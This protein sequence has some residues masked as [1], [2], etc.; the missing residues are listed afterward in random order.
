MVVT[1]IQMLTKAPSGT[2]PAGSGAPASAH[3]VV[4]VPP[5]VVAAQEACPERIME[6]FFEREQRTKGGSI[7]KTEFWTNTCSSPKRRRPTV[8]FRAH[9]ALRQET[10][11][12]LSLKV[13]RMEVLGRYIARGTRFHAAG[14]TPD[15]TCPQWRP[16]LP[17]P[18][19]IC[20]GTVQ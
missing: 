3:K 17:Y 7:K 19:L 2:L 1:T 12:H 4:G 13:P 14:K 20:A 5:I 8:G 16:A 15:A 9:T 6:S 10:H 18:R 11:W